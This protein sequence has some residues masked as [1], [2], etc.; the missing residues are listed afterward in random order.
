[1]LILCLMLA[2]CT[3][4]VETTD[5]TAAGG[6]NIGENNNNENNDQTPD[7]KPV[8]DVAGVEKDPLGA[9]GNATEKVDPVIQDDAKIVE[10]I[11]GAL[12]E[13]STTVSLSSPELLAMMGLSSP[14]SA[15]L[16]SDIANGKLHLSAPNF[17]DAE[18]PSALIDLYLDGS[19]IGVQSEVLFGFAGTY[20][21]DLSDQEKL[22]AFVE[23]LMALFTATPEE[24]DNTDPAPI[25]NIDPEFGVDELPAEGEAG[26]DPAIIEMYIQ[27]LEA[28]LATLEGYELD[29]EAIEA[30]V[31]GN[32][33]PV[34]KAED[35]KIGDT[36]VKCIG[37]TYTIDID[38]ICDI[39]TDVFAEIEIPADLLEIIN[40]MMG[41]AM[42]ETELRT[43][44]AEVIEQVRTQL[45]DEMAPKIVVKTLINAFTGK[46]HGMTLSIDA[47]LTSE[48]YDY[49]TDEIV[50]VTRDTTM[51]VEVLYADAGREITLTVKEGEDVTSMKA[52]LYRKVNGYDVT[53]TAGLEVVNDGETVKLEI[54]MVYNTKTG[55]ITVTLK[56]TANSETQMIILTGSAKA[57]GNTATFTVDTIAAE[58]QILNIGFAVTFTKGLDGAITIPADA[59]N[60]TTLTEEGIMELLAQMENGLIFQLI[61]GAQDPAMVP[62]GTYSCTNEEGLT[63]SYVF[64][65]NMFTAYMGSTPLGNA[66]YEI[67]GDQII[68]YM[69]VDGVPSEE[70][71][72]ASFE[73]GD[74]YIII[75]GITL[76]RVSDFI[77]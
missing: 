31:L 23:M 7:P 68:A 64:E 71:E 3:T 44:V 58:E 38:T 20:F 47:K 35:V 22:G 40:G 69:I 62:D 33:T 18:D 5:T 29:M 16:K 41:S 52:S 27:Q 25:D 9:I 51:T 15:T 21:A 61:G 70:G 65:G 73:I 28:I 13:G 26:F 46:L 6:N 59:T 39:I 56:M 60:I 30:A 2:S 75:G 8:V 34:V 24:P 50:S 36:T 12:T 67:D 63:M 48:E 54:P 17:L 77:E 14:V 10:I 53:Y 1:M 72:P 19:K 37:V 11:M 32:L 45:K 74:G 55:V 4:P 76:V 42:T 43:M 49:E 57:E 66:F